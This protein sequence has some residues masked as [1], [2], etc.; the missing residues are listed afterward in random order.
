MEQ[1][2]NVEIHTG[3]ADCLFKSHNGPAFFRQLTGRV[4]RTIRENP[5]GTIDVIR[6]K[7]GDEAVTRFAD[8]D[9]L[10]DRDS[11]SYEKFMELR[12]EE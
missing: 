1:L 8:L 3:D 6:R 2:H 12:E 4:S 7:G 5:D 11:E 9:D 10:E